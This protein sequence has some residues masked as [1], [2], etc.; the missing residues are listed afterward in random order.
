MAI[1]VRCFFALEDLSGNSFMLLTPG[2]NFNLFIEA[3]L[4]V[5]T[6]QFLRAHQ[7]KIQKTVCL[8]NYFFSVNWKVIRKQLI[9]SEK[10]SV[11]QPGINFIKISYSCNSV[12]PYFCK[13]G[14]FPTLTEIR[15]IIFH[16]NKEKFH[17]NTGKYPAF[18]RKK[19]ESSVYHFPYFSKNGR[20]S[21]I[22]GNTKVL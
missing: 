14:V 6:L 10:I 9:R 7:L 5:R 8:K 11:L 17:E 2:I 21:R 12:F 20:F 18:M 4:L 15:Y 1:F 13:M 19:Y 22:Y 16:V 3:T